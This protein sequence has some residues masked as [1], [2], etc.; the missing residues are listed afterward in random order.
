M[1]SRHYYM[2]SLFFFKYKQG[3]MHFDFHYFFSST[4]KFPF[5]NGNN[6]LINEYFCK[7]NHPIFRSRNPK[8]SF[9]ALS[10]KLWRSTDFISGGCQR[11]RQGNS[12]VIFFQIFFQQFILHVL[13]CLTCIFADFQ[14][15]YR[16]KFGANFFYVHI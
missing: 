15:S 14:C 1:F 12:V 13:I 7:L 9:L 16:A 8:T 11:G 3:L 5:A 2:F 4:T 6:K 10:V